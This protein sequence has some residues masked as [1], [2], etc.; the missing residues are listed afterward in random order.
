MDNKSKNDL[1]YFENLLYLL[2]EI[3]SKFGHAYSNKD[4]G[5]RNKYFR[6]KS[7]IYLSLFFIIKTLATMFIENEMFLML[8]GD[9]LIELKFRKTLYV[10]VDWLYF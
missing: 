7:I 9:F 4:Y 5:E 2:G 3:N 1:R 10:I 6:P 8:F